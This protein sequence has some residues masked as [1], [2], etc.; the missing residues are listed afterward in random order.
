[1]TIKT[2]LFSAIRPTI[3]GMK[4]AAA[5]LR[6]LGSMMSFRRIF[7]VVVKPL[8]SIKFGEC[9]ADA[10]LYRMRCIGLFTTSLQC[11][12]PKLVARH[13][14]PNGE[15]RDRRR[16]PVYLPGVEADYTPLQLDRHRDLVVEGL[17][18]AFCSWA[19]DNF[20]EHHWTGHT[21]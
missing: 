7:K 20:A 17:R 14:F 5:S 9:P 3:V 18:H 12:V 19:P 10:T 4:R 21:E 2:H 16:V 11:S 1:M 15:W 13:M 6:V 8:I